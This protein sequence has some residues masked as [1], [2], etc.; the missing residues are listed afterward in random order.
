MRLCQ[1]G[2]AAHAR[3]ATPA[4]FIELS[5]ETL[6]AAAFV[7]SYTS[8]RFYLLKGPDRRDH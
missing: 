5:A 8:P 6:R 7:Y 1:S 2:R 3:D 4:L